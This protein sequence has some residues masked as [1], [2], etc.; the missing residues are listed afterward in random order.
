VSIAFDELP[1][2]P[3]TPNHYPEVTFSAAPG[4]ANFILT[5]GPGK[6]LGSGVPGQPMPNCAEDTYLDFT[7]PVSG[8]QF[9]AVEANLP[10]VVAQFRVF[11]NGVYTASVDLVGSGGHGNQLV[12][13]SAF[14]HVTRL[15]IVNIFQSPS[16]NGIGWDDFRF[17]PD[18]PLMVYCASKLNSIGCLPAIAWTGLPSVAAGNGFTIRAANVRNQKSG[19][20][21]YS[22]SG[23]SA[24]PFQGGTLCVASPVRRTP[25]VNSGGSALPTSD[26]SGVYALDFNAFAAGALGGS[27]HPAL[28]TPGTAVDAQWWG[29]DPGFPPPNNSTLS[30]ALEFVMH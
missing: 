19:L 30:D 17:T 8:L 20:L 15:E 1:V 2:G 24:A 29:R 10:Q 14:S 4:K 26:C 5:F 18:A 27:P 23:R 25:G 28:Q 12:D 6:I 21:L 16:E 22:L 11:E 9:Q 7:W 13:L 3:L